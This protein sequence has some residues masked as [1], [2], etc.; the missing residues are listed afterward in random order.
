MVVIERPV[1]GR[2]IHDITI[3]AEGSV[4][5]AGR[6]FRGIDESGQ[7]VVLKFPL[8]GSTEHELLR[9]VGERID[10]PRML[11]GEVLDGPDCL[12]LPWLEGFHPT[13]EHLP[14]L[15]VPTLL[16]QLVDLLEELHAQGVVHRD[17]KPE[18]VLLVGDRVHL[19]DF[20]SAALDPDGLVAP[21]GSPAFMPPEALLRWEVGP[22]TDFYSL[23]ILLFELVTGRLPFAGASLQQDLLRKE[24][25]LLPAVTGTEA[26]AWWTTLVHHLLDPD[27]AERWTAPQVRGHLLLYRDAVIPGAVP[28]HVRAS[29]CRSE[30]A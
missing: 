20:G 14:R 12:R 5:A 30:T 22:A 23:G 21:E 2:R 15:D 28:R 13:H 27:P 26:D 17:L 24:A 9:R 10:H 4:D 25:G 8:P 3:T 1:C 11:V 7:S 16:V 6:V 19:I 29:A 18:N